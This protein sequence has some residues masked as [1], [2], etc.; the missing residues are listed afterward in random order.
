MQTIFECKELQALTEETNHKIKYRIE[1]FLTN[2]RAL[3]ENKFPQ[4]D[5]KMKEIVKTQMDNN[6]MLN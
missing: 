3:E 6:Q 4:Y 1:T 2:L 5:L